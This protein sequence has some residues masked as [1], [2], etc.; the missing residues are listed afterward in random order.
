[1]LDCVEAAQ[2]LTRGAVTATELTEIY[3]EAIECFNPALNCYLHVDRAGALAAARAADRRR[4]ANQLRG[5]LD[6][7]PVALKDNI[8]VAGWP[9]T[10]GLAFRAR[11]VAARDAAVTAGLREAG[12]VLLGSL[13]MDE[14]ALG[15]SANNPHFGAC[16][17]PLRSGWTAGG[18]S[19]GA[20]CAVRAGLAAL[21]LGS[22][23]M[24]SVRIPAAYCGVVALK[25][26]F[27]AIPLDGVVPLWSRLDHLGFLTRSVRDLTMLLHVATNVTEPDAEGSLTVGVLRLREHV[28][29]EPAVATAF[30]QA[31]QRLESVGYSLIEVDTG[32]YDPGIA[33]RAGFLLAERAFAYWLGDQ[34]LVP[35]ALSPSL[36]K[37]VDYGARQSAARV[38][39][40]QERLAEAVAQATT[41]FDH[42]DVL[43]SPTTPQRAFALEDVPPNSQADFTAFANFTGCPA[44]SVPAA[45]TVDS[46][47]AG[48]QLV[49]RPGQDRT[50]IRIA[51]QLEA[52]GP[53]E[54]PGTLAMR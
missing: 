49:T 41:W 45:H 43:V 22:D 2:L 5:P 44:V 26:T 28:E 50:L 13:N 1:M 25:P 15:A 42:C 8:A 31:L 10:A 29:L 37:L 16:H 12:A 3:L 51:A 40:A 46:L 36:K 9:H 54:L 14:G 35:G 17:N 7:I 32:V 19:G 53:M 18:S 30:E 20:G 23:S 48:V 4:R 11:L 24:G 34:R 47:P 21:A 6:G 38:E 52:P 39:A 27:G 33:R